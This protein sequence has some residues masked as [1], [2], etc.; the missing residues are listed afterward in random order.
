M[1]VG[2]QGNHGT[3]SEIAAL[4]YFKDKE[5]E[6]VGFKNFPSLFEA[7]AS[8]EIDYAVIPVENT[9]TGIISR[10]YDKFRDYD[11][12]AVGDVLCQFY[13]DLS[14]CVLLSCTNV[15]L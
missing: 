11:I 2:Y 12:H 14:H 5:I 6:Q 1:K 3:F 10:T 4:T 8:E 13:N 9:T 15:K 7:L